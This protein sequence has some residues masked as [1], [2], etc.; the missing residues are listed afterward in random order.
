MD[1]IWYLKNIPPQAQGKN[2]GW[3]SP[4]LANEIPFIHIWDDSLAAK[5]VQ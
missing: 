3:Q 4:V 5:A 2:V 1:Q